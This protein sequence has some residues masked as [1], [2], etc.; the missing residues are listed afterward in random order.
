MRT[1]NS[2]IDLLPV[3]GLSLALAS[4]WCGLSTSMAVAQPASE[5]REIRWA[6]VV[7]DGSIPFMNPENIVGYPDGQTPNAG[8]H[9]SA[10]CSKFLECSHE[11]GGDLAALLGVSQQVLDASDLIAFERN[12]TPGFGFEGSF[13][14][15]KADSKQENV[16]IPNAAHA[17]GTVSISAY[18]TYFGT[19]SSGTGDYPFILIDLHTVDPLAADFSVEV[20]AGAAVTQTP[21]VDAMGV[22]RV[23]YGA[24]WAA[25]VV[26]GT[27]GPANPNNMIGA[28]DGALITS[29]DDAIATVTGSQ[30]TICSFHDKLALA[31]ALGVTVAK[32]EQSDVI[33]F[34]FNGTPGLGFETSDWKFKVGGMSENIPIPSGANASGA[35]SIAAYESLFGV[36]TGLAVGDFP[37]VLIHLQSSLS[38]HDPALEIIVKSYGAPGLSP[39]IDAIGI[40]GTPVCNDTVGDSI[41]PYGSGCPGTAGF[42]PS[43]NVNGCVAPGGS[44]GLDIQKGKPGAT[45]VL[46][47]GFG[48]TP[49]NLTASCALQILPLFPNPVYLPNLTGSAPGQG[50]LNISG[51]GIPA[52]APNG[53]ALSLQV[54]FADAGAPGGV[55]ST[56]PVKIVI[57]P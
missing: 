31:S 55:A 19:T 44:I 14:K 17:T 41:L 36:S 4:L 34:E 9:G 5:V 54:V 38:A 39:D 57:G 13:W 29:P 40:L 37:F 21:D 25:T 10:V 2:K 23:P 53:V 43:L 15:F 20:V 46:F 56:N 33:A 48:T 6:T 26:P 12:G 16:S 8:E 30:F 50:T 18:N 51:L 22:F 49:A 52:S 11:A 7:Q 28:P 45:P 27:P 1:R 24:S 3:P 32:L 47:L 42:T 35:L